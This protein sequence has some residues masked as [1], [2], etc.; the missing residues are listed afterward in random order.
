MNLRSRKLGVAAA[1]A[2][3][4]A[5]FATWNEI[6]PSSS[7]PER[8]AKASSAPS[9]EVKGTRDDGEKIFRALAFGQGDMAYALGAEPILSTYRTTYSLNNRPDRKALADRVIHDIDT[10]D[11]NFFATFS[12]QMRSGDP[13]K[14][15][16]AIDRAESTA[17]SHL[18]A[19]PIPTPPVTPQGIYINFQ[20]NFNLVFNINTFVNENLA[21]NLNIYRAPVAPVP[22]TN[23][24]DYNNFTRETAVAAITS[25]LG[26]NRI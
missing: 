10:A 15:G 7:A 1:L 25:D 11:S 24:L 14:V 20:T 6:S 19:Q 9:A 8:S 5:G 21:F 22:N 16:T 13:F 26:S 18:A 3:S 17:V 4:I 23:N 2:I 12:I